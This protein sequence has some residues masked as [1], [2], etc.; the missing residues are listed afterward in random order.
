M[1]TL[2]MTVLFTRDKTKHSIIWNWA[3]ACDL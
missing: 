2:A 1:T 3:V